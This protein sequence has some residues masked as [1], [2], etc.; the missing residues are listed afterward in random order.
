MQLV[1]RMMC[2]V[3]ASVIQPSCFWAPCL[4]LVSWSPY[5]A[6]CHLILNVLTG[7]R[8]TNIPQ[9][10]HRRRFVSLAT[11]R[12]PTPPLFASLARGGAAADA[13]PRPRSPPRFTE[14]ETCGEPAPPP[15]WEEDDMDD[16]PPDWCDSPGDAG[17]APPPDDFGAPD[18]LASSLPRSPARSAV[19]SP[20]HAPSPAA[21]P[22]PGPSDPSEV[23]TATGA[24]GER[25]HWMFPVACT[26]EWSA[27]RRPPTSL[28]EDVAHR[29]C[30]RMGIQRGSQG[31]WRNNLGAGGGQGTLVEGGVAGDAP[32]PS[33]TVR[34]HPISQIR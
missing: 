26:R 14:D 6:G 28:A 24:R 9:A 33:Q 31:A 15:Q 7:I 10:G 17:Q 11:L 18:A 34:P 21:A 13:T 29:V 5:F 25:P 30:E 20:A 19:A 1:V 27:N 12:S 2:T 4:S 16:G 3:P 23:H 32:P 8:I 22:Q